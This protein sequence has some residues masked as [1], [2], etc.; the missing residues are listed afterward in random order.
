[1]SKTKISSQEYKKALEAVPGTLRKL[2]ADRDKWMG[3]ALQY[4]NRE[5]AQK[6]AHEMRE[7]GL[8]EDIDPEKLASD[9]ERAAQQGKLAHVRLAVDL[10]GPNMGSRI[11]HLSEESR[12]AGS[13][14]EN[15]LI[16]SVG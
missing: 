16:G 6:L 4:M 10:A 7:K 9:L 8:A 14:F 13:D 1:M 5:E 11:G 2:A 3:L 12:H 15:Y